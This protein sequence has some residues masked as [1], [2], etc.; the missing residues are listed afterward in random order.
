[1]DFAALTRAIMPLRRLSCMHMVAIMRALPRCTQSCCSSAFTTL[2]WPVIS[3]SRKTA[4][5][6]LS[7]EYT[8]PESALRTKEDQQKQSSQD[9][10]TC[11]SFTYKR[12]A[13]RS[14][15][16]P[17]FANPIAMNNTSSAAP[18]SSTTTSSCLSSSSSASSRSSPT[19]LAPT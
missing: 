15:C 18:S 3:N 6:R 19:L 12:R 2:A 11:T 8:F 9:P 16:N 13:V 1:M 4:S 10:M 17:Y 14:Q 7:T 5:R